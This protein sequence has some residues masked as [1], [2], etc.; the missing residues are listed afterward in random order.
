MT[1]TKTTWSSGEW[2]KL[3]RYLVD[4]FEERKRPTFGKS[5]SQVVIDRCIERSYR[6]KSC[7]DCR[8]TGFTADGACQRCNMTGFVVQSSVSKCELPATVCSRCRGCGRYWRAKY[9]LPSGDGAQPTRRFSTASPRTWDTM[10]TCVKCRGTGRTENLTVVPKNETSSTKDVSVLLEHGP[11]VALLARLR[12]VEPGLYL[13]LE[14]VYGE[15]GTDARRGRLSAIWEIT[16]TWRAGVRHA[17]ALD[18]ESG[19]IVACAAQ[20]MWDAD[21]KG[22]HYVER[23]L[24]KPTE[25][26]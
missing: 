21:A 14:R 9:P 25:G 7:P 1:T 2:R 17:A 5:A 26:S 15:E 8:K 4:H 3:Q 11:L 6:S 20:A 23:A 18:L 10:A 22:D 16:A 19:D 13:V 12:R 24:R